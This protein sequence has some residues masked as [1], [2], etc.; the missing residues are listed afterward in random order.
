MRSFFCVLA[1]VALSGCAAPGDA[2][3]CAGPACGDGPGGK[4]DGFGSTLEVVLTEP[5]CDRCTAADKDALLASSPVIARVVELIDGAEVSIDA[6]QFTFSRREIE[7]ALVRARDRG[8]TVRVAMDAAQDRDG[9]LSR[10]LRDDRGL[11]VRFVRGA[12]A[13][14]RFGI[15]HA[16]FMLVDGRSLL[17]GSNNWSSTG[18]SINEENTLVIHGAADPRL[19]GFACHF[20]AIWRADPGAAGACSNEHAAFTPASRAKNLIRDGIRSATRSVDV[21][22]H[23]LVFD[24]L[25]AELARAAERGVRV[26]VI[27]NAGDRHEHQGR[28]WDRL[29]A[30]GGLIRFKQ[31]NDDAY[32]LMHHKLAIVDDALLINGSGNW[33]GSAFFT[34]YENFVTYREPE[35]V[36]RF[37]DLFRRLWTWSLTGESL[38]AGRSAAEQHAEQTR[39]FFGN[40]HAHFHAVD[41]DGRLLD[42]GHAARLDDAG[43]EVPVETGRGAREA[44][45]FAFEYARDAGG[46]DFLA[47]T[48]HCSEERPDDPAD[49]PNMTDAGYAELRGAAADVSAE[50]AG[51]FLALAGAEWSTNSTGNHVNVLGSGAVPK[52]ERGRFDLLYG[53]LLAERSALGERPVVMMN[54]PRTFRRHEET[55]EGSWD[56]VFGV[57]LQEIANNSQRRQKFN[58]YGLDDFSPLREVRD[59]WI[60][61]LALPDEAIVHETLDN[62]WAASSPYARL[63]EVTVGRGTELGS[64]TPRNPSLSEREDGTIERVEKVHSD[65]DYYLSRGFRIAPVASHDNHYANWGTG[66][67]SRTGVIAEALDE[68]SL[69]DA[70]R[71]RA[72]FASEDEDL[73][74]GFYVDGRVPMGGETATTTDRLG[75]SVRLSDPTYAGDYEVRVYQGVVGGQAPVVSQT[76][77]VPAGWTA[78]DVALAGGTTFVYLEI[79][80]V[81]ADRMAW[82]APIWIERR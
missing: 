6:A 51:G 17:T 69:M 43:E 66:H 76:L 13:G 10:R 74:L 21:L 54:H 48:A 67:T 60:E 47:L 72:V 52:V 80:E 38:D 45:R 19:S 62:L 9:S 37:S 27:V 12:P 42:D 8:V 14:S 59:G 18:T 32:Q 81:G 49:L 70:L 58:D 78:F 2:S 1:L 71:D 16:K 55:L 68:R 20:E 82:S 23:H 41:A 39:V 53:E 57:S 26:R 28:R 46:L 36:S 7:E 61:G 31:N 25:V 4:A 15:M 22:M 44:A 77:T 63:M 5:F 79:L 30:A 75:A 50:S 29:F 24:D 64:E 3:P 34:N 73:E 40:L 33:S 11:D 56:Q 65:F 35:V